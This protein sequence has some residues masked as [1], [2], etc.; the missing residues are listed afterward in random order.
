MCEFWLKNHL[1]NILAYDKQTGTVNENIN[2]FASVF[3]LPKFSDPIYGYFFV[4][5]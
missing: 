4:Q 2:E 1:L 3:C 5:F